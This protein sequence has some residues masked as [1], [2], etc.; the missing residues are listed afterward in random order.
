MLY[1]ILSDAC[2]ASKHYS[3]S[4]PFSVFLPLFPFFGRSDL[5]HPRSKPRYGAQVGW[6]FRGSNIR[7]AFWFNSYIEGILGAF[8]SRMPILFNSLGI[9]SLF[10]PLHFRQADTVF[11][12]RTIKTMT[13]QREESSISCISSIL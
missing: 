10:F 3:T 12:L 8:S 7:P 2:P 1:D 11:S 4:N 5:F 6:T 9:R 13:L